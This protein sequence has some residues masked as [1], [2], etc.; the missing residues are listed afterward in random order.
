MSE[1][2]HAIEVRRQ[3]TWNEAGS[4]IGRE[5]ISSILV[6]TPTVATQNAPP[7]AVIGDALNVGSNWRLESKSFDSDGEIVG[8]D[9]DIR[10][11]AGGLLLQTTTTD[12]GL[13]FDPAGNDSVFAR[14]RVTDEQG[15]SDATEEPVNTTIG[16]G[17]S[18]PPVASFDENCIWEFCLYSDRSSDDERIVSRYWIVT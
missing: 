17:P 4:Q 12:P 9:W 3:T 1:S 13:G 10:S 5:K 16:G 18:D 15:E 6:A 2:L 11:P 14:L 8:Y 7:T